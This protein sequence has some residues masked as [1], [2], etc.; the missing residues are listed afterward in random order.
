MVDCIFCKIIKGEI[1]CAK[2]YEDKFTLAF[3]DINPATPRGGH[4]LILPKKHYELIT[5]LPEE[6]FSHLCKTIKK[7][8]SALLKYGEGLNII[9]NNKKVAGQIIPHVHFHLIPRFDK[10]GVILNYWKTHK[11]SDNELKSVSEKIKNLL[12]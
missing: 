9:Q 2:V 6:E 8:S 3:L 7:I 10:D 12:K 11:Y 5:D 4:V 1:P